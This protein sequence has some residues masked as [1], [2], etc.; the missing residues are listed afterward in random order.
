MLLRI[1]FAAVAL[2]AS[3]AQSEAQVSQSKPAPGSPDVI[4]ITLHPIATT[5]P[6][7]R[8]ALLPE[9]TQMTPGE[10]TFVYWLAG[11]LGSPTDKLEEL[12][13]RDYADI[14]LHDL[15]A[16]KVPEQL[17]MF[18]NRLRFTDLAARRQEV[19][20]DTTFQQDGVSALLPYLSDL[21]RDAKLLGWR[22][23]LELAHGDWNAANYTLQSGLSMCLQMNRRAVLVQGLVACGVS[24]I[25][26]DRVQE[27]IA[28]PGAP[29]LYWSLS[30]LPQP[31]FDL[32]P[33][34][35]NERA[36]IYY[37]FPELNQADPLA[38]TPEQWRQ[39]AASFEKLNESQPK[40]PH[41][42]EGQIAR[43]FVAASLAP[44]ARQHLVAMGIG[45]EK[46][47]AMS[48]D[49]AVGVYDLIRYRQLSD[50]CYKAWML[51]YWEGRQALERA[52]KEIQQERETSQNPLLLLPP[53]VTRA[54]VNFARVDRQICALR[55]IEALRDYAAR[56]DDQPP[57]ALD[58][59]VDLPVPIDP[60]SGKPFAYESHGQTAI[61]SAPGTTTGAPAVRYELTF[62][63]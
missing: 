15:P 53:A 46:V 54:R 27:W 4:Q 30:N 22:A 26:L 20:W 2:L 41:G 16:S 19:H 18:P 9:E 36:L 48:V 11:S 32:R 40:N 13:G 23:R 12:T 58:Q 33:M 17:A 44:Q 49:Q 24:S 50:E 10:A 52:M 25:M 7:L 35:Q 43:A 14:P 56:H 5:R 28:Q 42:I 62:T 29:N 45:L 38:I 34:Q 55:V 31:F 59:I 21:R 61:V 37:T 3:V 8:Y 60:I 1:A 57:A 6:V 63:K 39:V 51:P 47:D